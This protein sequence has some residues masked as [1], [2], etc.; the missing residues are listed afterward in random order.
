[1]HL[2]SWLSADCIHEREILEADSWQGSLS[3]CEMYA[4]V[5]VGDYKNNFLRLVS[6]FAAAQHMNKSPKAFS[7]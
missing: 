2:G 7:V 4:G 6:R 3:L 1:M 5:F